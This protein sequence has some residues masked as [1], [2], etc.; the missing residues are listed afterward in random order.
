MTRFTCLALLM[1][2]NACPSPGRPPQGLPDPGW[3]LPTPPRQSIEMASPPWPAPPL[4]RMASCHASSAD[5][6]RQLVC[7]AQTAHLYPA[8]AGRDLRSMRATMPADTLIAKLAAASVD[9]SGWLAVADA[10]FEDR[11]TAVIALEL[12]ARKSSGDPSLEAEIWS[13]ILTVA[14]ADLD[15]AAISNARKKLVVV[16]HSDAIVRF[17]LVHELAKARDAEGVRAICTGLSGE[18]DTRIVWPCIEGDPTGL[19]YYLPGLAKLPVLDYTDAKKLARLGGKRELPGLACLGGGHVG[20]SAVLPPMPRR[21]TP[22]PDH[23]PAPEEVEIYYRLHDGAPPQ[24][25]QC[26]L[27]WA[28]QSCLVLLESRNWCS[29]PYAL[30]DY[31]ATLTPNDRVNYLT[32]LFD[33]RREALNRWLSGSPQ[34]AMIVLNLHIML[35]NLLVYEPAR[36]TYWL[37]PY[38]IAAAAEMW[39]QF[40]DLRTPFAAMFS[41]DVLEGICDERARLCSAVCRQSHTS[42]RTCLTDCE[43]LKTRAVRAICQ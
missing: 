27:G 30:S 5:S 4:P 42:W 28:A 6:D 18:F 40:G 34:A 33:E 7:I 19:A 20:P 10:V 14:R 12:A 11:R 22:S 1:M 9:S 32:L 8:D 2:L 39:P 16:A 13:R 15:L 31:V 23:I 38:H 37:A 43:E 21:R 36:A 41:P 24:E 26:F 17:G 29:L 25:A 35:A 3:Q